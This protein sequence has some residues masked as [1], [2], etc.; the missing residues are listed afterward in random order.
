V[1][2]AVPT[3]VGGVSKLATIPLIETGNALTLK[4]IKT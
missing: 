3:V 4:D 2:I 1:T